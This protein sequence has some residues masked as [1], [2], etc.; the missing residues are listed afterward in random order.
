M[1]ERAIAA[2]DIPVGQSWAFHEHRTMAEIIAEEKTVT[3]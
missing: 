3:A 2:R 1:V